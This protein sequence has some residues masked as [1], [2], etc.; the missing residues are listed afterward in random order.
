MM[1]PIAQQISAY[2]VVVFIAYCAHIGFSEAVVINKVIFSRVECVNYPNAS[3]TNKKCKVNLISRE[4]LR[5]DIIFEIKRKFTTMFWHY[6]VYYQFSSNEY[7]PFLINVWD[8]FC[9]FME[10]RNNIIIGKLID[11]FREFTNLNHTCPYEKGSYFIRFNN[12]SVSTFNPNQFVPAGKYRLDVVVHEI[13]EGPPM[14]K[15]RLFGSIS[16]HRTEIF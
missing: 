14:V 2:A 8:D 5:A 1:K 13:F 11:V 9:S 7:R 10:G 3:I 16:D 15:L 6:V 4:N 12:F